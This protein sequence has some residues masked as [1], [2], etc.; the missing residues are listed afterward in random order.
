MLICF[1]TSI[2]FC[3]IAASPSS[4]SAE[5]LSLAASAAKV[6][7]AVLGK[8]PYLVHVKNRNGADNNERDNQ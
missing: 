5:V 7:T 6:S 2:A 3:F 4:S 1:A 8:I